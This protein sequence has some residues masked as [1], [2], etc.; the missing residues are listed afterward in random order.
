MPVNPLIKALVRTKFRFTSRQTADRQAERWLRY[1]L[2]LA[3]KLDASGGSRPVRVPAMQGVD[4]DM[5]DWSFFMLLEHNTIVNHAISRVVERLA[6]GWDPVQP[7]DIDPKTGVMPSA[8]PGPEQ[9]EA[10]RDS[11]RSHLK[12][13]ASLGQLRGTKTRE[14]PVFG[15]FDAHAWNCM[16]GFHL[17]V[18]AR[19]AKYIV[20]HSVN[21]G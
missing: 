20:Q 6:R 8:N 11:V 18:H 19:Q 2:G 5:R 17:Q 13:V 14:H 4:E 3:G 15:T 16:F 9:V 1:Y 7:G 12:M 10:F 21:T